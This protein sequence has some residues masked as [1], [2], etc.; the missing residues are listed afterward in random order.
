MDEEWKSVEQALTHILKMQFAQNDL[1][2][3]ATFWIAAF[4]KLESS[5][6]VQTKIQFGRPN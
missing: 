6:D 4:S 5:L 3:A 2:T 1:C